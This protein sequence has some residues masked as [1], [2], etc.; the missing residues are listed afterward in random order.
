MYTYLTTLLKLM[1]EQSWGMVLIYPGRFWIK[2]KNLSS[3]Q[4][5]R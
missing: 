3:K 2:F 5:L 4:I 1:V